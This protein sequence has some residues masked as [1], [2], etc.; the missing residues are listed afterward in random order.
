[1]VIVPVGSETEDK[2]ED[3]MEATARSPF[4]ELARVLVRIDHVADFI[5]NVDQ[6]D[7]ALIAAPRT[8]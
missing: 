5:V 8:S 4:F 3:A 7:A 1:M 2:F 6:I